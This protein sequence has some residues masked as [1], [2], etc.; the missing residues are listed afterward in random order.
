MEIH[1]EN[2][3]E[4]LQSIKHCIGMT[5]SN[6]VHEKTRDHIVEVLEKRIAELQDEVDVTIATQEFSKLHLMDVA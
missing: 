4:E 5:H 2:L 1:K 6:I 3:L